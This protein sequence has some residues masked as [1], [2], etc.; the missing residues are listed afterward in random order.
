MT[1]TLL[2]RWQTRLF[3]LMV[4]GLPM[5]LPIATGWLGTTIGW[6]YFLIIGY[7]AVLGIGWDF[8]YHYLQSW[9]WDRDWPGAFHLLAGIW[10]GLVIATLAATIGLPGVP[11]PPVWSDYVTHYS[12][13]WVTTYIGS[14]TLMRILFPHW[15]FWGGQIWK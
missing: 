10:E 1:P 11:R 13:V 4:V 12:L 14:Q 7:V 3:L 6:H 2:G 8:L 5:T 15:R 9:R